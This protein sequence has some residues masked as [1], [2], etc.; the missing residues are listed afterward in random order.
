MADPR[1]TPEPAVVAKNKSSA[2]RLGVG[3]VVVLLLGLIAWLLSDP[4]GEP[5]D[6][7]PRDQPGTEWHSENEGEA[8]LQQPP[9]VIPEQDPVEPAAPP[10]TSG[11][12]TQ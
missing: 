1:K 11:A 4:A 8:D 3:L 5:I 6:P 12:G 10:A 7:T 9:A 2:M